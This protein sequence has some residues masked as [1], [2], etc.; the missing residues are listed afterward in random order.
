MGKR[1]L[2]GLQ[3]LYGS[4]CRFFQDIVI[5]WNS[6]AHVGNYTS[7]SW[8]EKGSCRLREVYTTKNVREKRKIYV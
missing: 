1:I 3:L 5:E 8:Q 7:V 4:S 2:F 6:R